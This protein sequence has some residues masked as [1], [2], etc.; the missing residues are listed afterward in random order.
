MPERGH[1]GRGE[2]R[3]RG[4]GR[5]S[6][7]PA[8]AECWPAVSAA[9]TATPRSPVAP[10]S[11]TCRRWPRSTSTPHAGTVTAGGG[12]S[13]DALMK[14]LVPAGFFVPV[15]PGTRM[16]T[17]GGA[18]AADVHGKNHHVDGTFG[19]HVSRMTVVDG[20]GDLVTLSP[21]DGARALLGDRRGH[22][23]HRRHRRRDLRPD[24][25]HQLAHQRR[26][27]AGHRPRRRDGPHD[28]ARR[29]LPLQRRLDRQRA[30]GRSRRPDAGRPCARRLA[31]R[32]AGAGPAGLQSRRCWPPHR[33]SCPVDW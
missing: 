16:V 24:P 7:T 20:R 18:I 23:A 21:D 6:R 9:P 22:G 4:A 12:V 30:S 31:G 5:P 11:S 19:S 8:P 17:V 25:H 1:G 28:R 29:R 15:T 14:A 33:P 13:L 26:H 10:P 2:H 32:Q 3:R 27:R